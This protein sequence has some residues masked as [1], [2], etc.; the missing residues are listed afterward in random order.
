MKPPLQLSHMAVIHCFLLSFPSILSTI[1]TRISP[2]S[3][4]NLSHHRSHRSNTHQNNRTNRCLI[5]GPSLPICQPPLPPI[6]S[7]SSTP[8][9][10]PTLAANRCSVHWKRTKLPITTSIQFFYQSITIWDKLPPPSHSSTS[11]LLDLPILDQFPIIVAS[12]TNFW[13]FIIFT[14]YFP[15]II[16]MPFNFYVLTQK[17]K[18][19]N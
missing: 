11:N 16:I 14:H 2:P 4:P 12:D 1:R 15:L 18:K 5:R 10:K 7:A 6:C 17:P 13:L 8:S 3:K 9:F 19:E